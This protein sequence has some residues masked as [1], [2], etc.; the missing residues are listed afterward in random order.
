MP[1]NFIKLFP[2]LTLLQAQQLL[3]FRDEN[4]GSKLLLRVSS[5]SES[6][7]FLFPDMIN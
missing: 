7:Q 3:A 1:T 6:Y 5:L 4:I 2:L